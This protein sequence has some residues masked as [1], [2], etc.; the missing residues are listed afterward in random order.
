MFSSFWRW[1]QDIQPVSTT[2]TVSHTYYWLKTLMSGDIVYYNPNFK[3]PDTAEP[4]LRK[5]IAI[6]CV[7]GTADQP[8]SFSRIVERL[9]EKGLPDYVSTIHLVSFE[10]RYAG[11]GIKYFARELIKKI[12]ANEHEQV[13]LMGHSRGGLVISRAAEYLAARSGITVHALF[14]ICAPY[15]GSDW[16]MKP[17]SLFSISV[18]Q[19]EVKAELLEQLN[20]AVSD[21]KHDY[22]FIGAAE[23]AIVAPSASYV[24]DYVKTHPGSRLILDRHGHLSIM[25]SR[26]LVTYIH[27]KLIEIDHQLFPKVQKE[28]KEYEEDD[29]LSESSYTNS[30]YFKYLRSN[31]FNFSSSCHCNLAFS[32]VLINF[33]QSEL[34][35]FSHGLTGLAFAALSQRL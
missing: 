26:R 4:S 17:L 5:G 14:S 24:D 23:D 1:F 21:S 9:I 2:G 18:A 28:N 25:S 29:S 7:H 3:I 12:G 11:K 10:H 27:Q 33:K 6:Y 16:A 22:H 13:I 20:K 31:C 34:C 8:G 35:Q 19:M 30:Y 32:L 15:K